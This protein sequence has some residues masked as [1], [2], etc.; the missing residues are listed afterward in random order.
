MGTV[1]LIFT[2]E[3][4]HAVIESAGKFN[5]NFRINASAS[6]DLD[7]IITLTNNFA[8]GKIR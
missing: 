3:Q 7:F 6:H 8:T 1:N 2:G 4:P 5:F